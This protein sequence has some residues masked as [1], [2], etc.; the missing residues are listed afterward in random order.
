MCIT[1]AI[2]GIGV[3]AGELLPLKAESY[4]MATFGSIKNVNN[5]NLRAHF[6]EIC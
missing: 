2:L 6:S 5:L 3:R 4:V 1:S